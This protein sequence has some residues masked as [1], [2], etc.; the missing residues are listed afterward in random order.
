MKFINTAGFLELCVSSTVKDYMH[1]R[2]TLR[3]WATGQLAFHHRRERERESIFHIFRLCYKMLMIERTASYIH[4]A[5][6]SI[7]SVKVTISN[8]TT[9]IF[10]SS[11]TFPTSS[12]YI[13]TLNNW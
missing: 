11:T 9:Q 6:I 12:K 10:P 2:S 8:T 5:A 7:M 1:G 4:E 3:L 13:K